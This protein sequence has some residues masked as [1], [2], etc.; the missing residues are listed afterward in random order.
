MHWQRHGKSFYR[1]NLVDHCTIV[2]VCLCRSIELCSTKQTPKE[3]SIDIAKS[4]NLNP[5]CKSLHAEI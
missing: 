5:N 4:Q 3:D 1:A 2:A